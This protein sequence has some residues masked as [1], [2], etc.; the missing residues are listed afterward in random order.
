MRDLVNYYGS[1]AL[2]AWGALL[3]GVRTGES[4]FRTVFGDDL[5]GYL[6]A[7]PERGSVFNGAMAASAPIFETWQLRTHSPRRPRSSMSPGAR[8]R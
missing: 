3:H 1:E 8:G 2:A 7:H 4:P 6:H 5:F